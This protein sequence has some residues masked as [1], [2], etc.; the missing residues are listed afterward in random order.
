MKDGWIKFPDFYPPKFDLCLII[1]EFGI[2]QIAWW[3]GCRWEWGIKKIKGI[4]KKWK[5]IPRGYEFYE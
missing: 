1:D 2:E 5:K 3:V 4:I